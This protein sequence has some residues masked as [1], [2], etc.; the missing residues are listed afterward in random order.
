MFSNHIFYLFYQQSLNVNSLFAYK[1]HYSFTKNSL[2][3]LIAE[4]FTSNLNSILYIA[5]MTAINA[6]AVKL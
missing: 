6:K 1:V 5:S 3:H 4:S 2:M